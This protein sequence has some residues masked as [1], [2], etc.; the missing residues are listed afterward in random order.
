M[1]F[2]KQQFYIIFWADS[3]YELLTIFASYGHQPATRLLFFVGC[4]QLLCRV[5]AFT[6]PCQ[7]ICSP[8]STHIESS[9]CADSKISRF[10]NNYFL[11][12]QYHIFLVHLFCVL[13]ALKFACILCTLALHVGMATQPKYCTTANVYLCNILFTS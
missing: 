10:K 1:F 7:V 8:I 9:S 2:D 3:F 13:V 6:Y 5:N 11:F 4:Q 12:Q